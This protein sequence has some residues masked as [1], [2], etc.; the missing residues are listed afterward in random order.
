M[1]ASF[2]ISVSLLADD[3][4]DESTRATVVAELAEIDSLPDA[5][6]EPTVGDGECQ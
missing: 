4:G 2:L 6:V 1:R 5:E 3:C